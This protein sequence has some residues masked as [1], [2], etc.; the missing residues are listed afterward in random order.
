M[1]APTSPTKGQRQSR[2]TGFPE[3]LDNNRNTTLPH[4]DADLSPNA[5]IS[6]D[7]ISV[8]QIVKRRG[9]PFRHRRKRTVSHGFIGPHTEAVQG[10]IA[11]SF[12]DTSGNNSAADRA[13][14]RADSLDTS[15]LRIS[16]DGIDSMDESAADK[17]TPPSSPGLST[18]SRR[19]GFLSKWR[20]K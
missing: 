20:R 3:P 16:K 13:G 10:S 1:S 9:R 8:E 12:I 11:L 4:P 2:D 7:D 19:K 6:Q 18:H 5:F 17:D 15:S 14:D